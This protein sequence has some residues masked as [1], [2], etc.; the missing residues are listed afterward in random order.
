VPVLTLILPS[1]L[2]WKAPSGLAS[3]GAAGIVLCLFGTI[4]FEMEDF[5]RR[6]AV[7]LVRPR[8]WREGCT[9]D[10]RD[11]TVLRVLDIRLRLGH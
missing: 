4:S 9:T 2:C 7:T 11:L 8:V 10:E 5:A 3:G 6:M 1:V